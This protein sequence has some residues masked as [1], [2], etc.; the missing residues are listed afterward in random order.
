MKQCGFIFTS[1]ASS[2]K[3]KMG[4]GEKLKRG[5]EESFEKGSWK[6]IDIWSLL[7]PKV[8]GRKLPGEA[9]AA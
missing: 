3:L 1:A 4:R 2:A 5:D 9:P 8:F 7:H 6:R